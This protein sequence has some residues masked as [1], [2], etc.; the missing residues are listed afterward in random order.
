MVSNGDR[1]VRLAPGVRARPLVQRWPALAPMLP[2]ALG[3]LHL[4]D[5][6]VPVA[7]SYLKAPK[8]HAAAARDP[9]L[10][11]GRF[12]Q[13]PAERAGEIER[14]LDEMLVR[15]APRIEL[16]EAIHALDA[17]LRQMSGEPLEPLYDEVPGPLRGRIE[18]VYDREHRASFRLY[19]RLMYASPAWDPSLHAVVL[20]RPEVDE[21]PFSQNTPVLPEPDLHELNA[22]FGDERFDRI[23]GSRVAP[24]RYADMLDALGIDD[25]PLA[26]SLVVDADSVP[27]G[28]EALDVPLR[29]RCFSHA[30]MLVETPGAA[31]MVDPLI[32]TQAG[33]QGALTIE[34]VPPRIDAIMV[35]HGH[36][37]HVYV[38][39]LLQLRSRVDTVLVPQARGAGPAD[40]DLKLIFQALGFEDVRA[41]TEFDEI[42]VGDQHITALPFTGEHGGLDIAA[43]LAW[44]TR[45]GGESLMFAADAVG[46]D[47]MTAPAVRDLVGRVSQLYISM[48]CEG[49]PL[50]WLYEP[51]LTNGIDPQFD[52]TRRLAGSTPEQAL[53]MSRALGCEAVHVYAMGIEPWMRHLAGVSYDEDSIPLMAARTLMQRCHERGV[54]SELATC[55]WETVMR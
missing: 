51:L 48:E 40:P 44:L 10:Y 20:D 33:V 43:K 52:R 15:Q 18:L 35:T 28:V 39:T 16:A 45:A 21:R 50:S 5:R 26:R 55:G 27:S 11:A 54:R 3:S 22:P 4:R 13:V 9:R 49:A 36:D 24:L 42:Q 19:E 41:M 30:C 31:V 6:Q 23:F 53:E 38:E 46:A 17:R 29:V 8:I 12:M 47:T 25:G 14:L 34:D 32:T 7:R 37:D 2:P 1:L